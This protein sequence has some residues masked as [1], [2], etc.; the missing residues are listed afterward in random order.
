M[1]LGVPARHLRIPHTT[2]STLTRSLHLSCF[3]LASLLPCRLML[4]L[5]IIFT[6][7]SS[8]HNVKMQTDR[9]Q[10]RSHTTTMLL[11]LLECILLAPITIPAAIVNF[12]LALLAF[13]VAIPVVGFW[14]WWAICR[15]MLWLLITRVI[16]WAPFLL[17]RDRVSVH[18]HAKAVFGYSQDRD[19][20]LSSAPSTAAPKSPLPPHLATGILSQDYISRQASLRSLSTHLP[21]GDCDDSVSVPEVDND[22]DALYMAR[23]HA[24]VLQQPTFDTSIFS[25]PPSSRRPS[26]SSSLSRPPSTIWD[27]GLNSAFTQ[28]MRPPSRNESC[29]FASNPATPF[30]GNWTAGSAESQYFQLP[31]ATSPISLHGRRP[32]G[33]AGIHRKNNQ[34]TTSFVSLPEEMIEFKGHPDLMR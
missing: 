18:A 10:S 1:L 33:S 25:S 32:S 34:S 2:S 22:V 7:P 29:T 6:P 16:D 15:E 27:P 21:P 8:P 17:E 19:N 12:T 24:S 23:R 3:L 11:T 26:R 30:Q 31:Q 14:I 4:L 5:P 20:L 28:S 13:C 9:G